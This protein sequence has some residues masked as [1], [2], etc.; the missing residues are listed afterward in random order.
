MYAMPERFGAIKR[1]NIVQDDQ[2]FKRNM[3]AYVISEDASGFLVTGNASLKNNLKVWLN[4]NKMIT[5]S[6]DIIDA[7]VV[8][9]GIEY[10]A[11]GEMNQDNSGLLSQIASA[12][13]RKFRRY[14]DIS[15]NIYI[16]DIYSAIKNV[17]GVLDVLKAK[18]VLKVGGAYSDIFFDMETNL[19]ADGRMIKIPKNVIV[20]LKY[21]SADIQGTIK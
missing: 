6:I 16:S 3:N 21:P 14:Y 15:E 7:K 5:D 20:E 17:P 19:S 13:T 1:V 18:V 2:S 11:L 8:N 10:E 12:L 4:K 9:F